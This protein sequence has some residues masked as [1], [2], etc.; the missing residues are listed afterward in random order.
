MSEKAL[1]IAQATSKAWNEGFLNLAGLYLNELMSAES[2]EQFSRRLANS[3]IILSVLAESYGVMVRQKK[4]TPLEELDA[5]ERAKLWAEATSM[6]NK[7]AFMVN[8]EFD[9][10]V[11]AKHC[12]RVCKALYA[13]GCYSEL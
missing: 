7:D 6:V 4:I 10:E 11:C 1:Q 5:E 2:T 3:P 8:G 9:R 12:H 13:L